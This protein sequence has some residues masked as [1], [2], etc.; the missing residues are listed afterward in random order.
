MMMTIEPDVL[1]NSFNL[2]QKTTGFLTESGG[3]LRRVTTEFE[4][5]RYDF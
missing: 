4:L 5:V 3:W 1:L 2:E